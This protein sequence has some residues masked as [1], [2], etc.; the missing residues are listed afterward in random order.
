MRRTE[1]NDS[2]A[3]CLDKTRSLLRCRPIEITAGLHWD[4]TIRLVEAAR[5]N[6]QRTHPPRTFVLSVRVQ[7]LTVEQ[8]TYLNSVIMPDDDAS[9]SD[10]SSDGEPNGEPA[11]DSD[12]P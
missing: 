12:E 2:R 9:S 5:Q 1:S 11:E 4:L 6:M 3:S 10:E 8:V 7:L